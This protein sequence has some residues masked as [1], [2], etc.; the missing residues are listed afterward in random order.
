[1]VSLADDGERWLAIRGLTGLG[2]TGMGAFDWAADGKS[3]WIT[4]VGEDE[5]ALLNVDLQ[6]RARVA[7]RPKKMTVYWAIPSRDGRYL[8]LHVGSTSANAWMLERP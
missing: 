8:A 1:M 6:G 2:V 5:N 7:W 4:S 3:L